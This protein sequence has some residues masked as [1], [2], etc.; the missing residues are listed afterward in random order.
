MGKGDKESNSVEQIAQETEPSRPAWQ[1]T[2]IWPW[3]WEIAA[4]TLSMASMV[5][6]L[7]A[8]VRINNQSLDSWTLPIRPNS[9]IAIC[10]TVGKSAMLVSVASCIGQLKWRYF[11]Q[12][13]RRLD[14]LQTFDEASRGPWGAITVLVMKST[15]AWM[16]SALAFVTVVSLAI[17]PAAQQI[18][19]FRT[20]ETELVNITASVGI[21]NSF[22]TSDP[23]WC[24]I[25]HFLLLLLLLLLLL[26]LSIKKPLR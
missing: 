13:V 17:E 12:R 19:K 18:L 11:A 20:H 23:H 15:K 6:P 7:A 14:D 3:R 24:K 9:A 22:V 10:T 1:D 8:L 26:T 21:A 25:W 2:V 5:L 4:S 16:I